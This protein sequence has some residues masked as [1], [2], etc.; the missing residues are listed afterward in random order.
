MSVLR[1]AVHS[2]L[3]ACLLF[4]AVSLSGCGVLEVMMGGIDA[5]EPGPAESTSTVYYDTDEAALA[6]EESTGN[7][8]EEGVVFDNQ[9]IL[10]VQNGGTSPAFEIASE[11]IVATIETYHWNDARGTAAT[12]EISLR[13]DGGKVY[14]PWETI[15]RPGQG[16]VLN[17]YWAAS[18]NVTL[19]AGTYTVID[20][21]PNTWSQNADSSGEGFVIV[22][23]R[24]AQ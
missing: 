12:G 18:P 19:P 14:G 11:T 6:P 3:I 17:A 21:D 10:A 2:A 9:N 4:A 5:Y 24:S 23:A 15:G 13:G 1:L 8:A 7:E 22:R 16:D 20:S